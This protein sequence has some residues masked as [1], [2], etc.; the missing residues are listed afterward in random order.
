MRMRIWFLLTGCCLDD[1]QAPFNY[2]YKHSQKALSTLSIYK[3]VIRL[4]S[5]VLSKVDCKLV[6]DRQTCNQILLLQLKALGTLARLT[7]N[8]S[9]QGYPKSQ[10][11]IFFALTN[12]DC[13]DLG[14]SL[15]DKNMFKPRQ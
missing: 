13:F 4:K 8:L 10:P 2:K 12:F 6:A 7:H 3:I 9:Y 11:H 1:K 15:S 5:Q 14:T